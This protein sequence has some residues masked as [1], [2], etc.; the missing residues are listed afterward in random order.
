MH[1]W[2]SSVSVFQTDRPAPLRPAGLVPLGVLL[3]EALD[4]PLV[5][6][7]GADVRLGGDLDQRPLSVEPEGSSP[8][9]FMWAF[10]VSTE[11]MLSAF[12]SK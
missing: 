7:R 10:R 12:I 9:A 5:L 6:L 4:D 11:A 3:E 8:S 1:L 2:Y